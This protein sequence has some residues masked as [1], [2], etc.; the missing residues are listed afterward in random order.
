MPSSMNGKSTTPDGGISPQEKGRIEKSV[1]GLEQAPSTRQQLGPF[2]NWRAIQDAL[3]Q[4]FNNERIPLSKLKLMRRD[5]M[6]AFGMH[7]QKMPKVKAPWYMD[8]PD[9][10]L[11]AFM[12]G[13]L[14]PIIA[15]LIV[16]EEQ[17][18]DFGFQAITKRFQLK[19]P[20]GT[21]LD[22]NTGKEQPAW[23]TA[24]G[25]QPITLKPFVAL[26]PEG[27]EPI[28]D[29][30]TGEFAGIKYKPPQGSAPAAGGSKSKGAGGSSG[31]V[32]ID[33]YHSLWVTN[34]IESVFGNL[35]GYPR[36]GY[37]YPYWWSYWF[38]WAIA[39][40][41]FEKKGDPPIV[42]RHPEGTIDIGNG[43][44][45]QNQDYAL[46]MAERLRAGAA[47]AL[48]SQPYTN[49]EDRP[50]A[51]PE[52][53]IEY[54]KGGVEMEAFDSS[55]EYMDVMKLR[56]IFVPEQ[57]LIEGGG[58]T[59]SRN[60][61][62]EMFS[63][64]IEGQT[65]D[66]EEIVESVNRWIIPHLMLVNFPQQYEQGISCRMKVQGFTST[67][68]EL[69]S[70]VIQLIGQAT[71]AELGIDVR[72]ALKQMGIPL[73]SQTSYEEKLKVEGE[74]AAAQGP[75]KVDP[76]TTSSGVVPTSGRRPAT[77]DNTG[78]N[79]TIGSF[80]GF[81]D[82]MYVPPRGLGIELSAATEAAASFMAALPSIPAY[83][84]ATMRALTKRLWNAMEKLYRVSYDEFQDY[85][86]ELEQIQLSDEQQEMDFAISDIAREVG[87][88]VVNNWPGNMEL[89]DQT[90]S[91]LT[92]IVER[93]MTRASE[94]TR[95]D[96]GLETRMNES[97]IKDWVSSHIADLVPNSILNLREE[98]ADFV[99]KSF[100]ENEG[101][102]DGP[103]LA[104]M[105]NAHYSNF[106]KWM[107]SRFSRAEARDAFNAA[108]LLTGRDN[109]VTV[110]QAMDA[111]GGTTDRHCEERDGQLFPI[112]AALQ[113]EEHPS[114]TLSWRLVKEPV[115]LARVEIVPNAPTG[116]V[117]SIDYSTNTIYLSTEIDRA[118]EREFL[119][120]A[121]DAL[122]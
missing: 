66:M 6:L 101:P 25:I 108:T 9:P 61:A 73:L 43:E 26:P 85:L 76:T 11:A 12:D 45:I 109:G 13:T 97:N 14:R 17:K 59:S 5:P 91:V 106:P 2:T 1:R 8:S 51:V 84:D 46:L 65:L 119:L 117:G 68:T 38:R 34:E 37:A 78:R 122:S 53:A 94:I 83:E 111:L 40:R 36:L 4:P 88:K 31:E 98:L 64:L 82:Y 21:Y 86:N 112:D 57:A 71:P 79:Q 100:H 74:R 113:E 52:W 49:F 42:V 116:A 110:A 10:Q 115:T 20:E 54:L 24:G 81:S 7:Y 33:L 28:F 3:G 70:Q 48:P 60:V 18:K 41:A 103:H 29:E 56:S 114:G 27:V 104:K 47:V 62:E 120:A 50:S 44:E 93:M 87:R 15:S 77:A 92:D 32:E 102:I 58:G 89:L 80:T 96:A 118:S 19:S 121:G 23:N 30:A 22:P 63:G 55:F 16:T 105:V 95:K 69:L 39:D 35:F 99:G 72:A 67:D 75:P 107:A 90:T